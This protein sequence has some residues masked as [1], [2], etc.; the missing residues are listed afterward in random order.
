MTFITYLTVLYL[1]VV[2]LRIRNLLRL[3]IT[4]FKI[5]FKD[6]VLLKLT[7]NIIIKRMKECSVKRN[8]LVFVSKNI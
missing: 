1:I 2:D 6:F 3:G 8:I 5:F 4:F 7:Y